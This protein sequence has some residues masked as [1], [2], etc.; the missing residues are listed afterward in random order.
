[1]IVLTVLWFMLIWFR[2]FGNMVPHDKNSL[3]YMYNCRK[4]INKW[5]ICGTITVRKGF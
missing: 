4:D 1:M 5:L 3:K 2:S